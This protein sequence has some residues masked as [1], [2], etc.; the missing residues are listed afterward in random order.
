ML[1]LL[2]DPN[3]WLAFA[4]LA[5]LEIVLGIDNLIFISILAGKLPPDRQDLA[6]KVGIAA[7]L[8]SRLGLLFALT[9]IMKL[10]AP[11]FAVAGNEFSGKDLVLVFG[12]LFLIYKATIEIHDKLEGSDNA[13]TAIA[14]VTSF[15]AVIFQIMLIDVVFSLDSIITAVGMVAELSIMV[16]AIVAA[17]VF[18]FA[19]AGTVHGFV[20]RHPTIK[21]LALAFLLV[22][23]MA[24][25]ADGFD[26]H[27][28]KGYIYSAMAFSI[29]VE[30]LNIRLRRRGQPVHLHGPDVQPTPVCPTCGQAV[31]RPYLLKKG[32]GGIV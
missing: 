22:I 8:V 25:I 13:P 21:M 31:V 17:V 3:A 26:V 27:I 18:M 7:A 14:E 1:E 23:G 16:A 2:V 30:I 11:L 20:D 28:P 6:R 12:G 9:W 10:T 32:S 24:L 4:T 15:S 5:A 19:F 29:G